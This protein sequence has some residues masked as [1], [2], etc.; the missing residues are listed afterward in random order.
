[1]AKARRKKESKDRCR[2]LY[3][4]RRKDGLQRELEKNIMNKI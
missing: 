4:Q 3:E 1:M 2:E